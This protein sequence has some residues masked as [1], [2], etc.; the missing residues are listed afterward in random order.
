[1]R[2]SA[3]H[4]PFQYHSSSPVAIPLV[5]GAAPPQHK[6][7]WA[8][9]NHE[10]N[11]GAGAGTK[12]VLGFF[13]RIGAK[14]GKK[15]AGGSIA[16]RALRE[17]GIDGAQTM[18]GKSV[19]K[20]A[21]TEG[22]EEVAEQVLEAGTKD[23][24]G[25]LQKRMAAGTLTKATKGEAVDEIAEALIAR[26]FKDDIAREMAQSAVNRELKQQSIDAAAGYFGKRAL[27]GGIIAGVGYALWNFGAGA[28]GAVGDIFGTAGEEF[29]TNTYEWMADNPMIAAAGAGIGLLLVGGLLISLIAPL[30]VG[31]GAKKAVT[32]DKDDD[33][34]EDD[35]SD[36]DGE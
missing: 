29:V 36:E 22:G 33:K 13:G 5:L 3:V 20:R 11:A 32:K 15:I 9:E 7:D 23:T 12:T 2:M 10:F 21:L 17:G 18:F 26:G 31:A 1:M 16:E 4:N 6:G 35:S 19:G 14:G 30:L 25:I 8:S 34:E 28:I 27:Q 24:A